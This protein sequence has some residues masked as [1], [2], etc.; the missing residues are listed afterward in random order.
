MCYTF[1]QWLCDD[2]VSGIVGPRQPYTYIYINILFNFFSRSFYHFELGEIDV[3]LFSPLLLHENVEQKIV[4]HDRTQ[5]N[6][7]ILRKKKRQTSLHHHI[8]YLMK[9][10]QK[11]TD[12]V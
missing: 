11:K 7:Y 9:A 5:Y 3:D 2:R 12:K 4:M 6:M 1:G 10:I 8:S